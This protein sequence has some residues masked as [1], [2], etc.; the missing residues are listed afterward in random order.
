VVGRKGR[1]RHEHDEVAAA[2]ATTPG[3][4]RVR[5][6]RGLGRLRRRIGDAQEVL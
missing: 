6:A 3:A 4:A 2:L 1:A 5:V